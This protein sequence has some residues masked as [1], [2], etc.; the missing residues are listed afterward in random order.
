MPA[1]ALQ[2]SICVRLKRDQW[3]NGALDGAPNSNVA[4]TGDWVNE[5]GGVSAGEHIDGRSSGAFVGMVVGAVAVFEYAF[6]GS[7]IARWLIMMAGVL[8]G[9]AFGLLQARV[10][11]R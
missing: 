9:G 2:A 1:E 6:Y 10:T 5:G 4:V 7:T 3:R 8:G 11:A